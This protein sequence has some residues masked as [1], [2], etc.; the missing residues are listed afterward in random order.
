MVLWHAVDDEGEVLDMLVARTFC[1]ATDVSNVGL[2]EILCVRSV[3]LL[4]LEFV[5]TDDGELGPCFES[6]T[7]PPFLV[8]GRVVE[9]QIP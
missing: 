3:L 7:R 2:S 9:N 4:T 5:A 8:V 1:Y 6:F